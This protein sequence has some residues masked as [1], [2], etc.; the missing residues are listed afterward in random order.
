[1]AYND[2]FLQKKIQ[3]LKKKKKPKFFLMF[4]THI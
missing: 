4:S 3:L 1:M 2:M